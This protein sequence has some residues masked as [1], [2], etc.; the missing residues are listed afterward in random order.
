MPECTLIRHHTRV[1]YRHNIVVSRPWTP[2]RPG[3]SLVAGEVFDLQGLALIS[4]PLA[5][6]H[7]PQ[8]KQRPAV[9]FAHHRLRYDR[10]SGFKL[11]NH[12][13]KVLIH[14][15]SRT[16]AMEVGNR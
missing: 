2:R 5:V 14:L 15:D 8:I 3:Y 11:G 4:L 10:L 6:A 16:V 1:T 13:Q 9:G 12:A 7:G